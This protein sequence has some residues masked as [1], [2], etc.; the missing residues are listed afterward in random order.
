MRARSLNRCSVK[1]HG[2][3]ANRGAC[4]NCCACS[5]PLMA[6]SEVLASATTSTA[7]RGRADVHFVSPHRQ[8]VTPTRTFQPL[9]LL[10]LDAE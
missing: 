6:D 3:A 2:V 4:A 9:R 8:V 5:G 7:F 1:S 10:L